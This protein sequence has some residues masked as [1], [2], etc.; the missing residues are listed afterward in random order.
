[1]PTLVALRRFQE[2]ATLPK[3]AHDKMK[4]HVPN[5]AIPYQKP[6]TLKHRQKI[7]VLVVVKKKNFLMVHVII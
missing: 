3:F 6:K 5:K 1:V 2:N 7:S 4:N